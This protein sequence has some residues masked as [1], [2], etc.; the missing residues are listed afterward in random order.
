MFKFPLK[1]NSQKTLNLRVFRRPL[2]SFCFVLLRVRSFGPTIIITTSALL[3]ISDH[4]AVS[5]PIVYPPIPHHQQ[6]YP[7]S[8]RH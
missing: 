7:H 1:E 6:A 8:A 5:L 2:I 3:N 4:L